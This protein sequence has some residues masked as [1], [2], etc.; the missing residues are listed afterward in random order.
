MST[1][2]PELSGFFQSIGF[3][4]LLFALFCLAWLCFAFPTNSDAFAVCCH[5]FETHMLLGFDGGICFLACPITNKIQGSGQLLAKCNNRS[6]AKLP[7]AFQRLRN[8][9]GQSTRTC[10]VTKCMRRMRVFLNFDVNVED[11]HPD[12]EG[13]GQVQN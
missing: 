4:L 1:A 8:R 6:M 13:K 9:Y 10:F 7:K 12:S 11:N 5:A 3:A 2:R